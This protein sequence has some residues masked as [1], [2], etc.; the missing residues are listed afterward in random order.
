MFAFITCMCRRIKEYFF[1]TVPVEPIN[2]EHL[3]PLLRSSV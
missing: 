3:E 2:E 1:A